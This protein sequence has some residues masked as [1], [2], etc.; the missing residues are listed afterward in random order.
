MAHVKYCFRL[1]SFVLFKILWYT[2]DVNYSA[3]ND[4]VS[5]L[6]NIH[7]TDN[8]CGSKDNSS[9]GAD[10]SLTLKRATSASVHIARFYEF[11]V[12]GSFKKSMITFHTSS[13]QVTIPIFLPLMIRGLGI[14]R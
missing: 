7:P 2:F 5:I 1:M 14:R 8:S 10:D 9:T 12:F 6:V 13:K 11:R 4:S 3:N